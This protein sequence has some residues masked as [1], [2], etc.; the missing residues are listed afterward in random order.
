MTDTKHQSKGGVPGSL[1]GRVFQPMSF[2][3]LAEAV[4]LAF[5]YRGDVT[6]SLK[7]GKSLSGYL[8]NR[9][10][11]GSDSF[12]ELFPS[13]SADVRH[14]RYDQVAAIAFTGED[15]ATGKSWEAWIA[16]KDSE[17]RAEVERVAAE[18]KTRGIL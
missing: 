1:E 4:E 7:S 17:R 8:F 16:K 13:D 3:E 12:L 5:D 9:Q 18:A 15:T 2:A 11:N 10:V 14:I 6:V